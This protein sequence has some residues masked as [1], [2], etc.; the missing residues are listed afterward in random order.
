MIKRIIVSF[1]FVLSLSSI[2]A[3]SFRVEDIKNMF[4]KGNPLKLNGGISL[5]STI[6]AGNDG[7]D[8]QPFTYY[9]NGNVNL[10][11]LSLIDLPF[12]FSLTNSA[13]SFQ[14]PSLPNR[15]SIHPSYKWITAHIGD[16]DMT[17]SPYTLSGHQFTGAGVELT[18]DGWEF[19]TM[20]GRLLKAVEYNEEQ[21]AVLPN[22]KRMG[23]GFKAGRK[24]DNYEISINMLSAKDYISSLTYVPDSL[25]VSPMQNL[26][27][28]VSFLIKPVKFIEFSGEYAISLL[29]S[30]MRSPNADNETGIM[31][32]WSPSNMSSTYYNACKAQI[33]YVGENNRFGIGYERIAPDYKTLGAYYFTNDLENIT[34][35][36]SQS[37]WQNKLNIGLSIGY[38]HDDLAHSKANTSSRIVGSA[39]VSATF[40]ETVNAGISYSNFQTYTNVRSNFELVNQNNPLDKLDTLNFVQLSQTIN[41]NLN[42]VTK[43]SETQNQNL[44]LNFSFQEAANKQGGVFHP[45]SVTEMLNA[46]SG[47]TIS[48]LRSGLSVNGAISLNNSKMNNGNSIT[49]GPTLGASVP[50]FQKKVNV[51]S[52]LS[53]NSGYLE[54]VKQNEF[55]IY[56]LSGAYSPFKQHNINLAYNFQW[57]SVSGKSN[58]NSS[59]ITVGYSYSF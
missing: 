21:Q 49:W 41:A 57:R 9:L 59:L 19:A 16:V 46:S 24:A 43:K 28:G 50:L 7:S 22:Y 1:V 56:R 45:G 54:S 12:S 29:S 23:Y 18:P 39:N 52:T 17:F 51:T 40:S 8:R 2:Q 30:D 55:L 31:R 32:L 5:S 44:S 34:L 10:N 42:V 58:N 13:S 48:F 11:I 27:M 15:L 35:N 53:Y 26:A 25:G 33:A 20:Y 3:Q 37:L 38:E 6:D 36:G 4:G 14:S 47:Y